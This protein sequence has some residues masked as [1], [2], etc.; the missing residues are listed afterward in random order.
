MFQGI[1]VKKE[2]SLPDGPMGYEVKNQCSRCR[3]LDRENPVT[4]HA[5]PGGI[6]TVILLGDVDH[7]VPY[8]EEGVS[9][10]GLVFSP[11][12]DI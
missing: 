4:C 1:L 5:F 10:D 11:L 2:A 3:W 12:E 9:D 7:S 8:N 6:P